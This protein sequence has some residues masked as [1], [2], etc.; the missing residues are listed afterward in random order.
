MIDAQPGIAGKRIP[1]IFPE[2]VDPLPRMQ[3]PKPVGPTLANKL[4]IGF[5][6][7]RPKQGVVD[8]ALGRVHVDL[9]RHDV[10]VA[11]QNDR[12]AARK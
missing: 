1:E 3:R 5:P 7:L 6:H 10:V 4:A 2:G 11:G 9:G 12:R 8:P